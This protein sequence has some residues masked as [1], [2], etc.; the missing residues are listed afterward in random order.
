MIKVEG[1]EKVK[2]LLAD[3]KFTLGQKF[4]RMVVH[5][6]QQ[7]AVAEKEAFPNRGKNSPGY[8]TGQTANSI[9][10]KVVQNTSAKIEA[11]IG[12]GLGRPLDPARGT[13]GAWLVNYGFSKG[14]GG[15]PWFVPFKGNTSFQQWARDHGLEVKKNKKG[16]ITGGL[17]VGKPG[18]RMS[19]GI[20]FKGKAEAQIMPLLEASKKLFYAELKK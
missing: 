11:L 8:W 19:Q 13:Y 20:N 17:W 4:F 5:L 18:G 16:Q 6:A 9:G 12:P 2:A 14:N 1:I 3:K 10:Q 7:I 15:K